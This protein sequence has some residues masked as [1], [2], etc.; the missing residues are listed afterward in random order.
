MD[1]LCVASVVGRD[2][3]EQSVELCFNYGHHLEVDLYQEGELVKCEM[4]FQLWLVVVAC[5]VPSSPRFLLSLDNEV[6]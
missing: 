5:L 4:R 6:A 3:V 2:V 1:H